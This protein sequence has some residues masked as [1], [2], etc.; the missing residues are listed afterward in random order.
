MDNYRKRR[1]CRRCIYAMKNYFTLGNRFFLKNVSECTRNRP[2]CNKEKPFEEI[3][4]C[5]YFE[6]DKLSAL[7]GDAEQYMLYLSRKIEEIQDI[8]ID[9]A[10]AVVPDDESDFAQKL[11]KKNNKD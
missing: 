6:P 4:N 7:D 8:L 9:I 2:H 3:E 5:I 11:L 10:C 1:G